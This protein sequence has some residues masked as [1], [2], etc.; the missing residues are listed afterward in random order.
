M[1]SSRGCRNSWSEGEAAHRAWL[2]AHLAYARQ[3]EGREAFISPK[4]ACRFT[5]I[6]RGC[7]EARDQTGREEVRRDKSYPWRATDAGT[8]KWAAEAAHLTVLNPN[9]KFPKSQGFEAMMK[10]QDSSAP[11]HA[12]RASGLSTQQIS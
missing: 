1:E 3:S 10:E 11:G 4:G 12:T 8:V 9:S 2:M 6:A 5:S 7:E